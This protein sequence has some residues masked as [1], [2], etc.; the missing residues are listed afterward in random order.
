MVQWLEGGGGEGM[1]LNPLTRE[2]KPKQIVFCLTVNLTWC[3]FS[4]ISFRDSINET[5]TKH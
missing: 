4:L 3:L 5:T 2:M 1:L